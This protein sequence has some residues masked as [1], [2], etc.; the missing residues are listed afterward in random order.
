M[1]WWN[2]DVD[3]ELTDDDREHIAQM[4]KEGY[5]QGEICHED[6]DEPEN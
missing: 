6:E 1:A 2:L 3:V 5:T 4:I